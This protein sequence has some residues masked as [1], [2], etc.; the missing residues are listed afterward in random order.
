MNDLTKTAEHQT[1]LLDILPVSTNQLYANKA[2]GGRTKSAR[3][4]GWIRAISWDIAK[5]DI[6]KVHG[7]VE[8]AIYCKRPLNKDGSVS[9]VRRDIDNLIKCC[10]DMLVSNAFIEDDSKVMKVSAEW[11][12][13]PDITGTKITF[14]PHSSAGMRK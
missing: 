11:S 14:G 13:D 10:L 6:C 12:P 4:H 8:V 5:Q 9:K 7:L 2:R 1:I 3:Y